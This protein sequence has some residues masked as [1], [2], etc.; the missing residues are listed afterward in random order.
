MSLRASG[1]VAARKMMDSKASPSLAQPGMFFAFEFD[2]VHAHRGDANIQLGFHKVGSEAG[3][4]PARR[5]PV[6][7]G[8]LVLNARAD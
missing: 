8:A 2:Q 1:D 3:F 5:R 7:N 4:A 6:G